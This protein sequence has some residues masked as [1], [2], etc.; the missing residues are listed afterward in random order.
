MEIPKG[1]QVV[2]PYLIIDKGA[3]AFIDF[4]KKIFN[5]ELT[6]SAPREGDTTIM[7]AEINIGGCTIMFADATQQWTS[8]TANLFIYVEDVDK[9]YQLALDSGATSVMEPADQHYGRACG[10]KDPFGN[11][12]WMTGIL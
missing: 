2:M 6:Y 5:A 3:A 9:K 7:H 4:A 1:H 10:V 12:W 11:V 8:Q